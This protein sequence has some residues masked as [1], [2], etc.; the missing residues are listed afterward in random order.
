[1]CAC[2]AI[3]GYC[4][5]TLLTNNPACTPDEPFTRGGA[6]FGGGALAA[7]ILPRTPPGAPPAIP[8]ITPMLLLGG[9]A[10]SSTILAVFCGILVGVRST[11][12]TISVGTRFTT[13]A[14]CGGGGGGGG[15]GGA[16]RK[17]SSCLVGS[18]SV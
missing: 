1:M 9:G 17:V 15:G 13:G 12:S 14:A 7:K 8:P 3:C 6:T 4:G 5:V 2:R 10:S 11:L 16:T 18:A